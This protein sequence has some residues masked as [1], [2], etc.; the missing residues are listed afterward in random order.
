MFADC[1]LFLCK[2]DNSV[3]SLVSSHTMACPGGIRLVPSP[4]KRSKFIDLM[5]TCLIC[6][7][8]DHR[9]NLTCASAQGKKTLF[10]CMKARADD[11]DEL[12]SLCQANNIIDN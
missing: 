3:G 12:F 10:E 11:D 9:D 5:S 2:L 4:A 7:I 1:F 8:R 6:Q